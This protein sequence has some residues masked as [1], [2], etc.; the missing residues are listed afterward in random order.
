MDAGDQFRLLVVTNASDLATNPYISPYDQVVQ[1][2]IRLGHQAIR[3]YSPHFRVLASSAGTLEFAIPVPPV[4]A[5]DHTSTTGTGVPIY[6]LNGAKVADNY[7]DFYDGTWDSNEARIASGARKTVTLVW[8]GSNA[9]GTSFSGQELGNAGTI[10]GREGEDLVRVGSLASTS[11]TIS[12]GSERSRRRLPVYGLSPVFVVLP[13]VTI[14]GG[15]AVTEGN[16]ASFTVTAS[17]APTANLTVNLSVADVTG[18]DFVAAANE[19]NKSVVI[20]A[21]QNTATYTVDTVDDG[22]NEASGAVTVTVKDGTGYSVGTPSSAGVTVNDDDAPELTITGGAG[23]A[24]GGTASYT[25]TATVAPAADLT[26]NLSVADPAGSD[27]V[28]DDDE[29]SKTVTLAAG[30]T[31]VSYTV[32][33]VSDT[34]AAGDEASGPVTVTVETGTGYSVGTPS[35]AGV[36]VT[37]NDVTTVTLEGVAVN[38]P[39]GSSLEFSVRLNRA[40][41]S[42][43]TLPVPVTFGG[44]ASLADFSVT[45]PS[46]LPTGVSCAGLATTSATVT[47]TGPSANLATLT[48]TSVQDNT[49]EADPESLVIGLG[50]LGATSGTGLDGGVT[51]VDNLADFN[52][53]DAIGVALSF[54][55]EGTSVREGDTD[56]DTGVARF[57][58]YVASG[59]VPEGGVVIPFS[60]NTGTAL[61][62]DASS[63]DYGTV[64]A[65]ISIAAGAASGTATLSIVDDMVDELRENIRFRVTE[66]PPGYRFHGGAFDTAN[67]IVSILDND[68]TPVSLN[69]TGGGTFTEQDTTTSAAIRIRTA[70]RM[71]N[72]PLNPLGAETVVVPLTLASATGATLPGSASPMF[73]VTASGTGVSI[74]GANTA[75]P[76]ITF[77]GHATNMVQEAT[78][79]F[80]ATVNGDADATAETVTVTMGTPTSTNVDGGVSATMANSATLTIAD[81]D[82]APQLAV[83]LVGTDLA[84]VSVSEGETARIR[85]RRHGGDKSAA[86]SFSAT[87]TD[88][89]GFS[90]TFSSVTSIPA[91]QRSVDITYSVAEDNADVPRGEATYVLNANSAYTLSSMTSVSLEVVDNDPTGVVVVASDAAL[92]EGDSRGVT[93]SLG[94]GL[95]SG[96]ALVVP[97]TFG[98]T[99]TRG[100]DYTLEGTPGRGVSVQN[101]NSGSAS[102]TFTG[103]EAGETVRLF[104]MILTAE[105]DDVAEPDG[106]TVEIGP[107]TLNENSGTGLDGGASGTSRVSFSILDPVPNA[108]NLSVSDD[109][110]ATEGGDALTITATLDRA[111]ATGAAISIPIQADADGTTAQ[112]AD[113]TVASSISIADNAQS[114]TTSF[115]ATDDDVAESI[116]TVLM[117]LGGTL[118]D[119]IVSGEA[120]DVGISITDNDTAGLVISPTSLGVAEGADASYTVELATEPTSTVTVTIMV[121][122][123]TDLTLDKTSLTFSTSNWDDAQTVTVT[124]GEDDDT[125]DDTATLANEASG[126]GYDNVEADLA[127]TVTDNDTAGLVLSPTS[128]EVAEGADASYTVKLATQPTGTVTV[129]VSG[130]SGTD[131]TLDEMS[132]TFSTSTWD[133]AQTV[134]VTAGEDDDTANDTATLAHEA[135]GGGYDDVEADLAVT[136][137][138]DDTAGLVL[139]PTS[140]EVDEGT[141]ASYTVKLATEPTGTVTVAVSGHS[142]TDLT[143]D[144]TSL[145]FSTS[146]WDDAQ[147]VTVTAGEDD[148]TDDD[149]ATLAH[150]ASGGGYV[151]VEADLAVT[152]SDDDTPGLIFSPTSLGVAEGDDASYTVK[153]ATQPTGT[154]T[155]AISGQSGTDLMLDTTSL[156]F[157]TSTWNTAQTVT[158][159]AGEDDDTA[160]DTATLT[161]AASGGGYV[162]VEEDLAVT[163][164]DNDTANL[165]LSP[166]SLEV[167]EGDDASYTV[168]LATQPTGTVTVAVTGHSGTDLTLDTTSLEFTTSTWNTAQ[169]VTVTAGEDAD[170]ANDTA[171]LT[172]TASGGGYSVTA[173]LAVTVTDDDTLPEVSFAS[174]SSTAGEGDGTRNVTVNLSPAPTAATTTVSYTVGGTATAGDFSISGSGSLSVSSGATTASIPVAITDDME[175]ENS[176]TVL[177]TLTAGSGYTLGSPSS[178]TLTIVDD[179]GT[180]PPSVSLSASPNPVDEGSAVTVTARLSSALSGSVTVPLVLTA[181]TAEP[182]DYGSLASIT[183]SGGQTT[184]TG[185]VSTAQDADED[186]ETFTVALGTLPSDVIAGS[187]SSVQVTIR[188]DD[189]TTDPEPDPDPE[190]EPDPEPDPEPEPE[191]G[192]EP[193]SVSASCDPCEVHRGGEVELTATASDPDGDEL[194]YSWSAA[195]GSFREGTDEATVRWTAPETAGPVTI[196]V[197][198][199]DGHGGSASAEVTVAVANRPPTA[200]VSCDPCKVHRGGEA[201]LTATAS[202]PDGDPLTYSWSAPTGR[203]TGPT[204]RSSARWTAPAETGRVTITVRVSDGEDSVSATVTVEVVNRA[205]A[206]K[207]SVYRFELAENLDGSRQ[208]VHLGQAAAEDPDGD[209][210]TYDV[211]GGD[212]EHFR[213]GSR[214]GVVKYVGPGED[215]E[216]EPNRYELTV[217]ARDPHGAAAEAQV[218]ITVTN[219]NERPEAEDDAAE[220]LEDEAVTVDVLA[221][222]TDPDGDT[223]R[224]ESVSTPEHGTTRIA[225]G[226]GVLYTPEANY[227]GADRFTYVVTD[228]EGE[229]AS[230][231]VE[232]TVLS[233]N[234]APEAVGSIPDQPLDEGGG[235]VDI[236]LAPYFEDVDGDELAY[237]AASS[238]TDVATVRVVGAVLTVTPVVYGSAMVTVT[239]SDPE[240]LTATQT[241]TVGVDDRL[242]RAVLGHTLAAMARSHLASARMTLGRRVEAGRSDEPRLTVMGRAVPLGKA[243]ARQAAE[244]L[245]MG[246]LSSGAYAG[247]SAHGLGGSPFGPAGATPGLGGYPAGGFGGP[248][249]GG[250]AMGGPGLGGPMAVGMPPGSTGG[251]YGF[252]GFG[253]GPD[254]L[255]QGTEFELAL[256]SNEEDGGGGWLRRRLSVWGQGDIQAFHGTP[257]V[258]R[259]DARYDGDMR[260]GYVGVDARLTERWLAGV[261]V[262]RSGG[263][264]H[265]QVGASRGHLK[266]RLTALHPYAQWSDGTTSVWTMAGGG[267]GDGE[268]ENV[269]E[270]TG[271]LGTSTLGLRLGL[272]ELRRELGA[273]GGGA[274][275]GLRADAAWAE[276]RTGEGRESVD[277][278]TAPV[279]Q[280]RVGAEVSRPLRLGALALRPF[281]EAHLRRDAGGGQNGSGVELAFGLGLTGGLVRLDVQ[282]RTLAVHSAAGYGERGAGLTLT[283]GG[284]QREGLSLSVSPTWGDAASGTGALW[285]EEVYRHYL[286]E[287]EQD[288]FAVDARGDY[289]MRL[290]NGGLLTWFGSYSHSPYGR[291]FL[292]GGS[293][294]GL[295]DALLPGR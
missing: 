143:L 110:D 218:V 35:S 179:D 292:V 187:P 250:P 149:T 56:P 155:V 73:A 159:T 238:D 49:G 215:Y 43:E 123:G 107:G 280:Q 248:A 173:T 171:T 62:G 103:P 88:A 251:L 213:I 235:S 101:L 214:D 286:P 201:E 37:D 52:L 160:N 75:T 165:L 198:V 284:Q 14:T 8:T 279:N 81:D 275:F 136:V 243:A 76:T 228:P 252:G 124:A 83:A 216:S 253:G 45:C 98:G 144:E 166:T 164:T 132:L 167:D 285:Q 50:T 199:S 131:L 153:L 256:G 48:V 232:V 78:V 141:A 241:F 111:N 291:G 10:D 69:L 263:R 118:P 80:T 163:V 162:D 287:Q 104:S 257:T 18:S 109:G 267:W 186:N 28:A 231:A 42:G 189:G 183:I 96:E 115:T 79:T 129:A 269:R 116:E 209:A 64:P 236:E 156:E 4:V 15:A 7:T 93:M 6:W 120:N 207:E 259:Y 265:W 139:S 100:T 66:L 217:E 188:D 44:E 176:E 145:T 17:S 89:D 22:V 174:S 86:L 5:R 223:L 245:V 281:G 68:S 255:L 233:V 206:F 208:S 237:R 169:T 283:V 38:L 92:V 142:G 82:G 230:A 47:F 39:E 106:E 77:T 140:L 234:D 94:R 24:E 193:P 130:H 117:E 271:L 97:L 264:S 41:V 126:G 196:R 3:S 148:D 227:H 147:T 168:R 272:V 240:G 258:F 57:S 51:G 125:T 2:E 268:A 114:G 127:V 133:D 181:G 161:H 185:T 224:V 262:S 274:E 172:H 1:R 91:G 16:A 34:G 266:T 19:G 260:T 70:R 244:Q 105:T 74:S 194:T 278:L 128:L 150:E 33:T 29:G 87:A 200:R 211:S 85:V 226:G 113:Y 72:D 31:T 290:P 261:A 108:V 277:G 90:G 202:D 135:S 178:H 254:A 61:A 180:G 154:V 247:S 63:G 59:V 242:V 152:V 146:T 289:G 55:V 102:V 30:A 27:F 221:N 12:S 99:A 119:G 239:A 36:R 220:T 134:T 246:W 212:R 60:I 184:G 157:T 219:V 158:V 249:P 182:E 121:P 112:A 276:L 21:G 273:V 170:T 9:D 151:D 138:D 293:I 282:A 205:P 195:E 197:E 203:F 225:A 65:G 295:A 53:V 58:A 13:A 294:G 270:A 71:S 11:N 175:E 122:A 40:L 177:L 288:T 222:D 229:T 191:P 137:S 46:P 54:S 26:V 204:D 67:T 23:V 190:P 210:L 95:V 32:D 25:I 192:N 84:R 20:T